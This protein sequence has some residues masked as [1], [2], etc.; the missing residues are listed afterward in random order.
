M[1]C[2]LKSPASR[3]FTQAFI[4]A[5]IKENIKAPRHWPLWAEFT[6]DR[7]IPHTKS[8]YRGKCFHL[9]TSSW[10]TQGSL[11][12]TRRTSHSS[13][14]KVISHEI[15]TV[16]LRYRILSTGSWHPLKIIAYKTIEQEN[17]NHLPST[18]IMLLNNFIS[19]FRSVLK[20]VV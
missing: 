10:N 13:H 6:G 5:Q 12:L 15:I 16:H 14:A 2:R 19:S 9:M 1:R 17:A 8:Q 3:L 4:Q 11:S 7:W 20:G 18:M